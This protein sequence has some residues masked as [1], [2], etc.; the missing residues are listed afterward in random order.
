MRLGTAARFVDMPGGIRAQGPPAAKT[1][2][3]TLVKTDF[4]ILGD[5]TAAAFTI[6]LPTAVG[7][8]GQLFCVK[9]I[10]SSANAVT[11]DPSGAETIDGAATVSLGAQW[12][13]RLLI[14][15]GA[16]WLVL[17]SV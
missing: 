6:S 8:G 16:N 15:D 9:K 3:Y 5:A 2:A 1:A 12:A 7:I 14:S 17:A 10:D 4:V 11:I 13:S